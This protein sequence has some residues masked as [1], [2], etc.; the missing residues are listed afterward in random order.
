VT[1]DGHFRRTS[2]Y[3]QRPRYRCHP[4]DGSKRHAFGMPISVRHPTEAHPDAGEACPHCDHAYER[5]EGSRTGRHFTFSLHEVRDVLIR[6]G[7]GRSLRKTAY[8]AR[9]DMLRTVNRQ[10]KHIGPGQVSKEARLAMA[11]V[12]AYAPA[13]LDVLTPTH[14]PRV[15]AIDSM[16]LKTRG[17]RDG[18]KVGDIEAGE[19]MVAIDHTIRPGIPCLIQVHGGRDHEAW[20]DFFSS[21]GGE[22]EWIVADLDSA[23]A[24]AVRLKWPR[25]VLFRSRDHLMRLMQDRLI[26]DGIPA[27]VRI[28]NPIT[29][30]KPK[31]AIWPYNQKIQEFEPHPLHEATKWCQTTP[32]RWADFAALVEQ[33]IP[34]HRVSLRSWLATNE[35][36]IRVQMQ[37]AAASPGKPVGSGNV[38]GVIRAHIG[39]HIKPR[40]GRWQN[41][42]RLNKVLALMMLHVRR[43]DR[44]AR[45]LGLLRSRFSASGNLSGVADWSRWNDKGGSSIARLVYE[46]DLRQKSN[47]R[48]AIVRAA[49]QRKVRR[50]FD[51]NE[52]RAAKGLPPIGPTGRT[53]SQGGRRVR[54]VR[55]KYAADFPDLMRDWAWDLNYDHDPARMRGTDQTYVWWRCHH[56]PDHVWDARVIERARRQNRC[57][58]CTGHRV[59]PKESLSAFDPDLAR[60]WH[61]TDNR[62]RRPE[63]FLP[64]SAFRATWQCATCQHVWPAMIFSRAKDRAGCPECFRRELAERT[65]AGRERAKSQ[66]EK[67]AES[68]AVPP[69]PGQPLAPDELAEP[70]VPF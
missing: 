6:V 21:L 13:V 2:L 49:A 50:I 57:A 68:G 9:D 39:T 59:H 53:R 31:R 43:E 44:P 61:P 28:E 70:D 17:Y 58:Y 18:K 62:G 3:H 65:R 8:A 32:E 37:L 1:L 30:P 19:I 67:A 42:E 64:G 10:W 51:E 33:F 60:E 34:H 66:R 26:E 23:I 41:R 22:P 40:A 11:Y 16:P 48:R 25:A 27:Q 36:L 4:S 56:D 69:P 35:P 38:E 5:H 47:E 15:I 46:A 55:G 14:W 63:E 52:R 24:K 20:I 29:K 7:E 54:S 12:D 45:Y